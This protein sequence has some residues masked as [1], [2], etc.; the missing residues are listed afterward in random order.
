[1]L[2]KFVC[3][4]LSVLMIAVSALL[5]LISVISTTYIS[6]Y[7]SVYYVS[8]QPW[9][10]M[11]IIAA[12]VAVLYYLKK[13][14]IHL[15]RRAVLIAGAAIFALLF[16]FLM[17]SG[18]KPRF[19]QRHVMQVAAQMLNGDYEE[20]EKGGY[21]EIYPYQNGLLLFYELLEHIMGTTDALGIQIVNL[22]MMAAAIIA[23]YLICR[24]LTAGYLYTTMAT[25]LFLPF[26]GF[27]TLIYGNIPGFAFGMWALY[28]SLRY[29]KDKKVWQ[30]PAAAVCMAISRSL[31][32]NFMILMIAILILLVIQ[33]INDREYRYLLFGLIMAATVTAG[34]KCV[35]AAVTAQTGMQ[36]T[37]GI[38]GISYI[39]MGLHEHTGRGAGWH[40]N[41]PENTYEAAGHDAAKTSEESKKDIAASV[42]NF[43]E[44]PK[45]TAGFFLRKIASMWNEPSYDSL[46]MQMCRDSDRAVAPW[47]TS[48]INKGRENSFIYELMNILETAVIFGTLVFFIMNFKNDDFKKYIFALFFFGGFL[49]HLLWEA[50]SQ[51]AVFYVMLLS[52]YAAEG[53]LGITDAIGKI[54]RK[55]VLIYAGCIAAAIMM[56][57]LPQ[58][59]GFLTLSRSNA[60][61]AAYLTLK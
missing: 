27:V 61:Y 4:A 16:V 11:I 33:T 34:N 31:K 37:E 20:F 3:R 28:F 47:V 19:D 56:L 12:L 58:T 18:L 23:L 35:D 45:Y 39:A 40:D 51:Y 22:F 59:A 24:I 6:E 2:N 38:P 52:P 10:H 5:L 57:S 43:R 48:M 7:E 44:H 14:D 60:D 13:R 53:Y 50:S 25:M 9:K 8:D 41:Y 36:V 29:L 21:A 1:M 55:R 54:G 17:S 42:L 15:S 32:M 26:W 49:C 46:S 30:I